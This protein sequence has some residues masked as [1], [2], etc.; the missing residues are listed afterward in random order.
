MD[1]A[2]GKYVLRGVIGHGGMGVVYEAWDP[3]LQRAVAIKLLNGLEHPPEDVIERFRR[4]AQIVA[5]LNHPNIVTVHDLGED[6]GVPFIVMELVR[7]ASLSDEIRGR[8]PRSISEKVRAIGDACLALQC[9]H[10]AGVVHR[11]VKPA[12]IHLAANGSVKLLDFGVAHLAGS[13]LTRSHDLLGTPAYIPP[14]MVQGHALD[15]RGDIYSLCATLYEWITFTRPFDAPQ[16]DALLWRI[17]HEPPRPVRQLAPECPPRLAAVIE[18]GLAKDRRAR[19]QTATDLRIALASSLEDL[20]D[21]AAIAATAALTRG[22]KRGT[23]TLI[24]PRTIAAAAAAVI[25]LAAIFAIPTWQQPS[26]VTPASTQAPPPAPPASQAQTPP[27]IPAR[28][29]TQRAQPQSEVSLPPSAPDRSADV[30]APLRN[31]PV[32]TNS[33]SR[34][35]LPAPARQ[36]ADAAAVAAEPDTAAGDD[37]TTSAPEGIVVPVGT[38]LSVRILSQLRTDR[39]KAGDRFA[40]VLNA[41]LIIDGR[42]ILDAGAAISGRVDSAGVTRGQAPRAFLEISLF[43]VARGAARLPLHTARYR[44][45]GPEA[46]AGGGVMPIVIGAAIGTV[47]GGVAAGTDGA[48]I[49]G[50]AGAAI[51]AAARG[52]SSSPREY[53]LG[54][55]LTFKL[56]K[57]IVITP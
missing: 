4:E 19:P 17:L 1:R 34:D 39:S 24:R 47:A 36:D 23:V 28:D 11:D 44:V 16:V 55:R 57:A 32:R 2:V 37:A 48:V 35:S 18:Q 10:D 8:T 30:P 33:P 3:T 51:G 41:P 22:D 9:A 29:A 45:E 38:A 56:A 20:P 6:S 12:N 46:A 42:Q 27:A 21:T 53:A 31:T 14:E 43:D 50:A 7:G 52:S 13:S 26:T 25:L 49:G 54:D 5:A 15:A 40:A